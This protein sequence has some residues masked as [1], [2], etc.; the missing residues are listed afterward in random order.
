M[1]LS[2]ELFLGSWGFLGKSQTSH[3]RSRQDE[4]VPSRNIEKEHSD[5]DAP[6][7]FKNSRTPESILFAVPGAGNARR[8]NVA[9]R[10]GC[11]NP[12]AVTSGS[13]AGGAV[14]NAT[15]I[16]WTDYTI[17]PVHGCSKP[18]T[19][20]REYLSIAERVSGPVAE[21]WFHDGTGKLRQ[22]AVIG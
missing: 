20:P 2:I 1:G 4:N 16:V 15:I 18:P 14:A 22:L 21:K 13:R 12:T 3:G 8:D 11:M 10:G 9:Y 5:Y 6:N 7:H 19:V 17:N